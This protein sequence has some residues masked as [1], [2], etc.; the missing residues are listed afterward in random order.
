MSQTLTRNYIHLVFSTK[1]RA[2]TLP[3]S[4]LAEIYSYMAEVFKACHCPAI[5]I[6]GTSNHVHALFCL[7]KTKPLSEVV[8]TVKSSTTRWINKACG[9]TL[10][11]FSW[12]DGYGAFSIG[13]RNVQATIDYINS[14]N[15]H[16]HRCT[17]QE[18]FRKICLLY[19]VGLDERY[20]WD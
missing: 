3:K 18:E 14:Q 11:M 13:Q 6:G 8:G 12:Q 17:F 10:T 19:D 4:H 1:G 7:D 5:C 9:N 2:E 15:E 20:A 16:H